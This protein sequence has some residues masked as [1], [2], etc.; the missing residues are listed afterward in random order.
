MITTL[1]LSGLA[2][3]LKTLFSFLPQVTEMPAWY[4][5]VQETLSVFSALGAFPI[6]GTVIQITLLA[7]LVLSGWQV[8]VFFNWTYNKLRGSG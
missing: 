3:T 6:L 2:L 5:P 4:I 7:L 1:I 8:V